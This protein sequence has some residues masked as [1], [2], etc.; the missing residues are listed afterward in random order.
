MEIR[1]WSAWPAFGAT[2]VRVGPEIPEP[3]PGFGEG[4]AVAEPEIRELDVEKKV[5]V[6][7]EA[8]IVDNQFVRFDY[9]SA[10]LAEGLTPEMKG[11]LDGIVGG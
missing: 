2:S 6:L 4:A 1:N 3:P 9:Q 10:A 8:E 11:F 7:A 5:T